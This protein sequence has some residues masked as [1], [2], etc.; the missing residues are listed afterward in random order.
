MMYFGDFAADETVYITF[1]TFDSDGASVTVTNL[2]TT[3]IHLHKDGGTTQR[4]TDAGYTLSIDFDGITGN[5][6][7]AIDLSDNTSTGWYTTAT[8]YQVRV[9]GITVDSQTIN[10]W[11]GSFSIENRSALKPSTAGRTLAIDANGYLDV[12]DGT[13]DYAE[14]TRVGFAVLAGLSS[15]GGTSTHKY[16]NP[17]GVKTRVSATVGGSGDRTAISLDGSS[18]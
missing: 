9:E 13:Y 16:F 12:N 6:I 15:G 10:A 8:D 18:S 3:D 7:I 5:H 4:A 2:A 14:M 17:T 1:N 11:I